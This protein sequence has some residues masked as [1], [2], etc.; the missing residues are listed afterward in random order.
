M[1]NLMNDC[2]R[3]TSFFLPLNLLVVLCTILAETNSG[4]V[5]YVSPTEPLSSCFR[6]SNCPPGQ[7]CHT[8]D[9][10]AEHGSEFFSSDHINVTL[11]FMCGVHNYS[12]NLNVQNL[13]SFII[14]GES[15]ENV[16]VNHQFSSQKF[17]GESSCT[18]IQFFNISFVKITN[19][20]MMCPSLNIM[21]SFIAVK[22]SNLYGYSGIKEILSF[23]TI[24]GKGSQALLDDCIFKE[25][26]FITSNYSDGISVNNSTFQ[27][28][29]HQTNSIIVALSSVVT[30][31][32]NVNFTDCVTGINQPQ[33][34][35]GTAVFLKTTNMEQ[36]SSLNITIAATVYFVNLTCSNDGGAVYGENAMIQIDDKVRVIFMRNAADSFGGAVYVIDGMITMGTESHV[37]T[38]CTLTTVEQFGSVMDH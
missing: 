23:I 37:V 36:K 17:N 27:S 20:T 15:R 34:S 12:K 4:V 9:Y 13:Y 33:Y 2:T 8:M 11:I 18:L 30:L 21:N 32:G 22:N 26:C 3:M 31:T 14:Q 1:C 16:I 25:N 29:K 35:S 28:Y 19:L 38:L 5:Y 10:L 6:N 24:T 7:L